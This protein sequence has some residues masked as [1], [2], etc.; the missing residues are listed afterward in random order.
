MHIL[1]THTPAHFT[2]RL[3]EHRKLGRIEWQKMPHADEA[4]GF[5]KNFN[6]YFQNPENHEIH[7]P[8]KLND[9]C[10]IDSDSDTF[11]RCKIIGIDINEIK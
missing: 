7:Y 4:F 10:V 8:P 1:A 6:E 11:D 5:Q 3:L 9:L 2:V